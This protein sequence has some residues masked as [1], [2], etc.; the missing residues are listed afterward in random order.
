MDSEASKMKQER[1]I[2]EFVDKLQNYIIDPN[3]VR[4]TYKILGRMNK[5]KNDLSLSAYE[6]EVFE[7]QVMDRLLGMQDGQIDDD[8]RQ[9]RLLR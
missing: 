8:A 4:D 3:E 9:K 5:I 2:R 6:T 7:E 1:A